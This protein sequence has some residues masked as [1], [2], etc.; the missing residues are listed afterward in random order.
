MTSSK[1]PPADSSDHSP[2]SDSL[3]APPTASDQPSDTS[4]PAGRPKRRTQGERRSASRAAILTAARA[5]FLERG[6]GAVSLKDIGV[7]AGRTRGALYHQFDDKAAVLEAVIQEEAAGMREHMRS[8]LANVPHPLEKLR[9]GF[10]TYLDALQDNRLLRLIHVEYPAT[11]G[12]I[13]STLGSAWLAYV[14]GL[15]G[16]AIAQGLLRPVGVRAMS[17]LILAF[18]REALIAISYAEDPAQTRA[19]MT[20]A[21]DVIM[22]GLR[23][24]GTRSV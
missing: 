12:P 24:D 7:R 21:L 5:E 23:A 2:R 11:C 19:E 6:Y 3:P 9:L 14:E 1:P 13:R 8:H 15:V 18:Y 16:E 10:S 17:R 4:R 20:A 22:D